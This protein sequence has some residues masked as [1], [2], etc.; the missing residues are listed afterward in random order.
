[1]TTTIRLASASDAAQIAA[2]YGPFCTGSS[3]SFE[4]S[5]PS[6]EMMAQRIMV[7]SERLPWLVLDHDSQIAGYVYAGV[8]RERAAYQWAVDVT[9]Y[10]AASERRTGVG[11]A[12]YTSLMLLLVAQGY[13]KAYAGITLPNPASVGLHRALGFTPVGIYRG[14]GYK[15]G[16]WHDVG[17]YQKELQPERPA[18]PPPQTIHQISSAAWTEAIAAGLAG[19]R[20]THAR[21][22]E[23]A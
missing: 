9:A 7:T 19:Y 15:L 13:F 11:R 20:G 12:L 22:T 5:A 3:V 10:I 14:V 6:P 23:D 4:V 8:H 21:D 18:P 16:Q 17:W 1:M 2:I